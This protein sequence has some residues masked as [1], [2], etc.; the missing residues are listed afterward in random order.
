ARSSIL[1][2]V[3]FLSG[4]AVLFVPPLSR[5][6][7]GIYFSSILMARVLIVTIFMFFVPSCVLGMA[8]PMV[9]RLALGSLE[10]AGSHV[11]KIYAFSTLGSIVGTFT[12]GFFLISWMGAGNLLFAIAVLLMVFSFL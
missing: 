7:G 2:W 12:T 9:V 6:L 3:L 4:L 10:N 11:G 5:T 8:L 1:G